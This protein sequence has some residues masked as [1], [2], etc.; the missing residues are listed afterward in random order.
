MK[1]FLSDVSDTID[2]F[3]A[4]I[5][6]VLGTL[7]G[8]ALVFGVPGFIAWTLI[9]E[10][11]PVVG[12]LVAAML[13]LAIFGV[14]RDLRAQRISWLS[15]VLAALWTICVAYVGIRMVIA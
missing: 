6:L 15:A 13:A 12:G 10:G 11:R 9:R 7:L 2:A 4:G 5:V 3:E 14:V 1:R 8:L